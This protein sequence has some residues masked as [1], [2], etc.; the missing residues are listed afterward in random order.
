MKPWSGPSPADG[1]TFAPP[2]KQAPVITTDPLEG[3]EAA[4]TIVNHPGLITI[5]LRRRCWLCLTPASPNRSSENRHIQQ[6]AF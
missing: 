2:D 3:K 4:I 5:K 6:A 1:S